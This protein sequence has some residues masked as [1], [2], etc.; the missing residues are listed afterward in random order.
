MSMGPL[1][2]SRPWETR[3]VVGSQRFLQRLWRNVVDEGTGATVVSDEAPSVETLKV[4][5]RAIADTTAD[6]A[7]MRINT[8]IS[9]LIVLNNH[10]TTLPTTPRAAAEALVLMTAPVARTS[11]GA[12]VAAGPRAL[13]SRTSRSRWPT[14]RTWS[15]TP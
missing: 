15:R 12:V 14:R 10:L 1:D 4:L 9:R 2:L 7:A 11:R 8:A 5:H 13:R 6:M 3:A